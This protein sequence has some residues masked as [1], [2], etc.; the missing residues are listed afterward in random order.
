M[1][2]SAYCCTR[3]A[4]QDMGEGAPGLLRGVG[5]TMAAQDMGAHQGF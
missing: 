1:E 5:G 4:A 3:R 2:I